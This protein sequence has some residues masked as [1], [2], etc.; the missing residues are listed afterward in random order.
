MSTIFLCQRVAPEMMARRHGRIVTI[1][2]TAAFRGRSSGAIYATAKAAVVQYTRC[3]AE[4]LR[5]Y[6]VTAN[7]IAPGDTRTGR[8]L[9]T[10]AVDP[11]RLAEG[12]T[13]DRIALVDEVARV[14]ALFAGPMG[15]FIT[16][17]VLRVDG[18][19]QAWP[20]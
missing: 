16:G 18:G 1:S 15:D 3:L 8:F 9:N 20:A 5:P 12:G 4:Q 14:V 2:S 7:S 6:G 19:A 11:A 13:L 17:Q 10:R